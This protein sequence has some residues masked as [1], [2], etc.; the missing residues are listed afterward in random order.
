MVVFLIVGLL[1]ACGGGETDSTDT[2]SSDSADSSSESS[3]A[4]DSGD[5]EATTSDEPVVLRIGWAGSPDTLNPGTA[6][7]S[8]A[9][10][11]FE[12]VYDSMYQLELDGTYSL[13]LADSVDVSDDGLVYTYHIRDGITFHD[14]EPLTAADVAFSYNLY[15]TQEDFPSCPSTPNFSTPLK[16]M[17]ATTSSSPSP[18]PSPTSKASSS[19]FTWFPNTFGAAWKGQPWPNLR[20]MR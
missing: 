5:A 13:E 18:M 8:E 1:V 4:A 17:T 19:S 9:Y 11:L 10:T 6:V 20:M 16:P 15:A 14:G 12:L 2:D 3:E 7:L